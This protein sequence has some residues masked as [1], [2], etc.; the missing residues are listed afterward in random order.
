MS[1]FCMFWT[2][3]VLFFWFSVGSIAAGSNAAG[4]IAADSGKSGG[5]WALIFG[6]VVSGLHYFFSPLINAE[7]FGLSRWFFA[8]V[9]IVFIPV[10]LPFLLFAV[11]GLFKDLADPA[12][13]VLF[14]LIPEG[15]VRA[16]SWGA[17]NDPVYL[18]L[19]PLLWTVLA[20]GISFL[21]RLTRSRSFPGL[22]PF[23]LA[24]F[25]MPFAAAAVFWAFYGQMVLVGVLLLAVVSIPAVI[26]LGAV[27][28]GKIPL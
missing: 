25:L 11:L 1:F 15:V 20:L 16:V 28:F 2:P 8:L 21:V 5:V 17:K 26:A 19:V 4:I 18:I 12:K 9:D 23:L 14:A 10:I 6:I 7:G 27:F 22:I 3:L 13:F 24:V